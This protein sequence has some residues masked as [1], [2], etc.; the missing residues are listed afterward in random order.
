MYGT[1]TLYG[2]AFL[3]ASTKHWI[4]NS[5]TGLV[6]RLSD[7]TTPNRQRHQALT[8]ARFRLIPFR[9]PLLRESLLLSFPQ[10]TEM[11]QFPW[12]PSTGPMCSGRSTAVFRDGGFPH[13]DIHGSMLGRQLPVA[14]RSHPRPS[15]ASGAKASTVGSCSLE[16]KMLVLAMQFS[17]SVEALKRLSKR[18]IGP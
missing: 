15:S 14:F 4:C 17:R 9:S 7:P 3:T 6:P 12:F 13:S 16:N 10:G 2:A 5:V 18:W 8:P 1:I 11:F